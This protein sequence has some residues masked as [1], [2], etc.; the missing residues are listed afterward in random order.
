MSEENELQS[1]E[2]Q[3][4]KVHIITIVY[5]EDESIPVVNL[6]DVHPQIAIPLLKQTI[7]CLYHYCLSE[8][9]IIF[10]D[11]TIYSPDLLDEEDE[12]E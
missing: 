6:G 10:N 11:T 1:E 2:D 12:G 3:L 5:D 7:D 4:R 9:K 8:P